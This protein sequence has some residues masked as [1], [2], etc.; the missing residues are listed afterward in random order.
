MDLRNVMQYRSGK[1]AA[2]G[3]GEFNEMRNRVVLAIVVS[4][5]AIG[6]LVWTVNRYGL[7]DRSRP[8]H[9]ANSN[10]GPTSRPTEPQLS[11]EERKRIREQSGADSRYPWISAVDLKARIDRH[12]KLFILNTRSSISDPILPGALEVLEDDVE[13][14]AA[15]VPKSASIV[16][17]CS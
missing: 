3:L 5:A 13:S 7:M 17:Y 12:E 16:T 14:W 8:M 2:S 6:L 1:V 10:A 4:L 9:T 11:A 15:K